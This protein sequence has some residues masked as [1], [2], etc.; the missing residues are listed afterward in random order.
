MPSRKMSLGGTKVAGPTNIE[1][2]VIN[3]MLEKYHHNSEE[4]RFDKTYVKF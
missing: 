4:E 2:S 1:F 3:E